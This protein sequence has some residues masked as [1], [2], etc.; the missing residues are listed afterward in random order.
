MRRLREVRASILTALLSLSAVSSSTELLAV[1][2]S[3]PSL[4][5]RSMTSWLEIPRSRASWKTLTF[6][7]RLTSLACRVARGDHGRLALSRRRLLSGLLGR[8]RLLGLPRFRRGQLGGLGCQAL[9]LL[10]CR[11]LRR[12]LF[13]GQPLRLQPLRFQPGRL[14]GV[15]L[16][17]LHLR[18]DG[19]LAD[20]LRRLRPDPFDGAD[21]LVGHLEDVREPGH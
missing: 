12:G 14:L 9:L 20:L 18:L 17:P 11:L 7:I 8:E 4:F 6:T 16:V 5:K 3:T 19:R 2:T 13:G 21:L 10:G 1:F 15:P